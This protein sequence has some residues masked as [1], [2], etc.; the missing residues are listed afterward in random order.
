MKEP[1]TWDRWGISHKKRKSRKNIMKQKIKMC[2]TCGHIF[3]DGIFTRSKLRNIKIKIY[4]RKKKTPDACAV[5]RCSTVH[6]SRAHHSLPYFY[7]FSFS[8]TKNEQ[9]SRMFAGLI[10]VFI[11]F[12]RIAV[13][14]EMVS[15]RLRLPI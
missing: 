11:L 14:S 8:P 10:S 7:L 5:V 12:L 1:R 15:F 2:T 4:R 13:I 9:H 6:C 3:L